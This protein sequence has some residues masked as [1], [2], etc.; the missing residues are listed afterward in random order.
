MKSILLPLLGLALTASMAQAKL[1]VVATTGDLGA[2]ASEIGGDR[3]ELSVLVMPT[4]DPHLVDAKP[5]FIVKLN[6]ADVMIEG[7]A[8]LE[9]G[10][11]PALLDQARNSKIVG[12]A[13]GHISCAS[14]VPLLDVPATPDRSRGDIHA[15]GNPHYVIAPSNAKIVAKNIME[16]FCANDPQ[17]ADFYRANLKKFDDE[18][19]AKLVEWH[20]QLDPFRGRSIVAYHDSWPY[21]AKEFG[22]KIDLFLE[23]KPGS[24][25][26]PAHLAEVT[27]K[28]RPEDAR[29]IIVEPYLNRK[30][31][32][33]VAGDANA[34][35]V[36][37]TQFPG[38]INGTEGGYIPMVDQLVKKLARALTGNT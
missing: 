37:V 31:A 2:I 5:S 28:M 30:T 13:S 11:L 7:G 23:L 14:G 22:L 33:T 8:G 18:I 20:K 19:D 21:F 29:V 35:I 16:G 34:W 17:A 4:E 38:G 1:N 25:P 32:E 15:A 24:P 27:M 3:I 6:R 36:E 12:G 10:W 9:I 26:T